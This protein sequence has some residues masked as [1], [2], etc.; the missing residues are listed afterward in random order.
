MDAQATLE[1]GTEAPVARRVVPLVNKTDLGVPPQVVCT[2]L[3]LDV[4]AG[5]DH[6]AER[7]G[8]RAYTAVPSGSA[9]KD[10]AAQVSARML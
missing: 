9:L 7:G 10:T 3:A 8:S 1:I 5:N 6:S 2:Y 4:A